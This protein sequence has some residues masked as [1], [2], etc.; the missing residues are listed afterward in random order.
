M[1]LML[2]AHKIPLPAHGG[3]LWHIIA[4]EI[5]YLNVLT[6]IGAIS[7]IYLLSGRRF[8]G[9]EALLIYGFLGFAGGKV[10]CRCHAFLS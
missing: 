5:N 10:N 2:P 1:E 9:R 4:F 3:I 6:A 7:L 8:R